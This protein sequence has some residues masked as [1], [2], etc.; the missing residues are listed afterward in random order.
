M[1]PETTKLDIDLA[2]K[3][4]EE[5][6]AG[7]EWLKFLA[8]QEAG[9]LDNAEGFALF[10]R[11]LWNRPIPQMAYDEW[12]VPMYEAKK[13]GRGIV[14]W[15]A[16]G[17]TKT[18]TVTLTFTAFQ[19]GLHPQESNLL[20]MDTDKSALLRGREISRILD[21]NPA[22][23]KLF[24]YIVKDKEAGWSENGY[25]I[26]DSRMEHG[27]FVRAKSAKTPDPTLFISGV[28]GSVIG[29]HP[30]NMLIFDDIH[31]AKNTRSD[32]LLSEV[33]EIVTGTILPTTS[34]PG[35]TIP[36]KIFIG[37]P[38]TH[39]DI[40]TYLLST[41]LY[42]SAKT[43]IMRRD[44]DGE[45]VYDGKYS[46][47]WP[48]G[49]G[50]P[51]IREKMKEWGDLQFARMGM[52]DLEKASGIHLK[53]EWLHDY[54]F[55]KIDD[56]WPTVMGV[57]YA[58]TA[59]MWESKGRERD[60]F[61]IAVGKVI[62]GNGGVVLTHG[63]RGHVSQGEA[64]KQLVSM[65]ATEPTLQQIGVEGDGKGEEFI[66]LLLRTT[67]LPI[68]PLKTGGTSKG[69]RFE[70]QMAPAFQYNRARVSDADDAFLT[71]FREEWIRFP[72]AP[73][74]DTLDA[75]FWMLYTARADLFTMPEST[76]GLIATNPLNT[77]YQKLK[78]PNPYNFGRN[79]GR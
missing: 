11:L 6:D 12:V 23:K 45:E 32:R 17:L 36:F 5:L 21:L 20:I 53:R 71:A 18:T 59:D 24:P 76:G 8:L 26:W 70:R 78:K 50:I 47:T 28:T 37:T 43:P 2:G 42:E 72:N 57:D 66:H 4:P 49:Y 25:N 44:P 30:T 64:E 55:D 52:L 27:D 34:I 38:W 56:K 68:V 63:F 54:P 73:H 40:L 33:R 39:N 79:N 41:E 51:A 69:H 9:E 74:D 22:Y 62:P 7:E 29:K 60:Y 16:R 65:A 10:Y 14:I 19:I 61:C 31:N 35:K 46:P 67:A 48:E 13:N 1:I 77:R 15:A 3:T 75:V 58:S